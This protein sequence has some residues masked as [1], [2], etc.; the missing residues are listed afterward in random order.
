MSWNGA[1]GITHFIVYAGDNEKSLK[2]I[3]LTRR[4]SFE[5]KVMVPSGAKVAKLA[6]VWN[7][8][9]HKSPQLRKS[10]IVH[11]VCWER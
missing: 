9:N 10:S 7:E 6:A 11:I 3:G 2:T 1:T 8:E 4:N 5:T